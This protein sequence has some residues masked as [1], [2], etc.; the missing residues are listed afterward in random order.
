MNPE[1]P[2]TALGALRMMPSTASEIGR[3]SKQL[4]EGVQE[5][6]INP[7]ELLV[8]LRALEGVS[9]TV[10][11]AIKDNIQTAADKYSEKSFD[12]FGARVEKSEVG[13]KY[14]YEVCQDQV[15]ERHSVDERTAAE[16][17]KQREVFLRSLT[18]PMTI[19][20]KDSGEISEIRPPLKR[21]QSGVKIY[22]K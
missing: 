1:A 15:W 21:S 7:L 12:V 11:D 5:G 2:S 16:L 20:D 19:V 14:N 17:R 4:I 8:M 10:R 9:E 3:F 22:L 18:E 13:V 6:N